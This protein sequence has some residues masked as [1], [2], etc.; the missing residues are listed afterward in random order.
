M[1]VVLKVR[2]LTAH[3]FVPKQKIIHKVL[4]DRLVNVYKSKLN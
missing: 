3:K 4:T 2:G 1:K